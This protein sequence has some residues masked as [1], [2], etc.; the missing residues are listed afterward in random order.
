MASN[1]LNIS[2]SGVV[3][4][5]G[6]SD[7]TGT[8]YGTAGQVLTS[9]GSPNDPTWQNTSSASD[10][11]TAKFIVSSEGTSGTGANF[12]NITAAIAS[13]QGT[14]V[15]STIFIMPGLTGTYT[16][17]FILPANINL[18]SFNCDAFTANVTIVGKI[19][20]T[21]AGS[22]S[23]S[24]IR[25]Q[26]NSD[27]FLA[28]TGNLATVVN[29][30]NCY[31]NCTNNT[32]ISFTSSSGSSGL[33]IMYCQ[34]NIGTTGIGIFA[35]SSSGISRIY[36][37][38]FE[39][40]GGS[41]TASTISA[42]SITIRKSVV[43]NPI[44]T[45]GTA[46]FACDYF[47]INTATQNVTSFTSGGSSISSITYSRF[48]SGTAPAISLTNSV[49]LVNSDL[50]SSNTNAISGNATLTCSPIAFIGGS[51]GIQSTVTIV[52]FPFGPPFYTYP[53]QG[54][55]VTVD[56]D[57]NNAY[58]ITAATTQTLPASPEQGD[59]IK[60]ICDTAGTV[61]IQANTGQTI[62]K[63]TLT[64]TVAGTATNSAQGDAIELSYRT[65]GAVWIAQSSIGTWILA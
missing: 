60:L 47:G 30:T 51:K 32:G 50:H 49:A 28:V 8:G 39:N 6:T 29:L 54:S 21:D 42:G 2:E 25:L 14:G 31:L 41:S 9:N 7:F 63:G 36:Y 46:S 26:T 58:F 40:T 12:T 10:L 61:I 16:E 33:N 55:S 1:S 15:K 45:S 59:V 35:Y 34:G 48:I 56:E 64:S 38:D 4:F 53:D 65:T 17:N 57:L 37:S 5:D 19:T 22:R 20:C 11:H 13:A 23:I 24:G 18:C 27:F 3:V 52:K 62:R 44:T 43:F